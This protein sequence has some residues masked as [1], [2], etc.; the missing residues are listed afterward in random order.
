[1]PRTKKSEV[2]ENPVKAESKEQAPKKGRGRPRKTVDEIVSTKVAAEVPEGEDAPKVSRRH[3]DLKDYMA[4]TADYIFVEKLTKA[5]REDVK[6][7]T[8][9]DLRNLTKLYHSYQSMRIRMFNQFGATFAAG[10]PQSSTF[11]YL[12]NNM[13]VM[14]KRIEQIMDVWTNAHP[15][16]RWLRS[17]YGVGPVFAASLIGYIDVTKAK[18]AAQVWSFAGLSPL[19]K[20]QRGEKCNWNADLKC[21]CYLIADSLVCCGKISPERYLEKIQDWN[22]AH[23]DDPKYVTQEALDAVTAAYNSD[24]NVYHRLYRERRDYE[25]AKNLNRDYTDQATAL[26]ADKNF[27][28]E[29]ALKAL[30][31]GMLTPGHIDARAKRYAVKMLLAH[32]F[33]IMYEGKYGV[34]PTPYAIAHLDHVDIIPCPNYDEFIEDIRAAGDLL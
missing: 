5:I 23:P 34:V 26:L 8:R 11:G 32:T 10:R 31:D 29:A 9:Y 4:E 17:I 13:L 16:G 19:Q 7:L 30:K 33:E 24:S 18:S 25:L 6:T 20:R 12:A 3:S 2:S 14:E 22:E 15:V 1:M 21:T 28:S 27:T